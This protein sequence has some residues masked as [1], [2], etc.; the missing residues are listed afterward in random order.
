[1]ASASPAERRRDRQC[2]WAT[3]RDC[4]A[5][6]DPSTRVR[7]FVNRDGVDPRARSSDPHYVTSLSFFGAG[8]GDH[9]AQH[10]GHDGMPAG[11]STCISMDLTPALA[12]LRSTR[13]A[14]T[15]RITIQLLPVC[16]SGNRST[17]VM[18]ASL[19]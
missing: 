18:R 2:I 9:H 16:R 14:Q 11:G 15:D 3:L 13:Y 17:S 4:D 12:R 7:V 1:M 5:P 10:T 8:H 6:T 19:R